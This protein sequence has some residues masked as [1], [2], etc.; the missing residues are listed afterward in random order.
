MLAL[1]SATSGLSDAG[2]SHRDSAT[3]RRSDSLLRGPGSAEAG[4][5][6]AG[7]RGDRGRRLRG[8]FLLKTVSSAKPRLEAAAESSSS[9]HVGRL[10]DRISS[11][12]G[13]QLAFLP[14]QSL[15]PFMEIWFKG[16]T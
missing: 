12:R 9:K 13:V 10:R 4:G 8:C 2:R 3:L 16:R 15:F 7:L 14:P 6:A 11:V 5:L 1:G